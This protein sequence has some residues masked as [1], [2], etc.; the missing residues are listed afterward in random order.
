MSEYAGGSY[1]SR[2]VPFGPGYIS[3]QED[4]KKPLNSKE[5]EYFEKYKE[6]ME[7][8]VKKDEF[9]GGLEHGRKEGWDKYTTGADSVSRKGLEL[10]EIARADESTCQFS[11]RA[12]RPRAAAGT[13]KS[14][15]C[16]YDRMFSVL[17]ELYNSADAVSA[18]TS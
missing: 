17:R 3:V 8:K 11:S 13:V 5:K 15:G 18:L 7:F 6:Y 16:K 14:S 4:E 10:K 12:V 1:I 2:G 9:E